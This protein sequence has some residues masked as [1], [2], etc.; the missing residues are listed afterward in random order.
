[1]DEQS[2][3]KSYS[4]RMQSFVSDPELE[5]LDLK[6]DPYLEIHQIDD[7]LFG[8]DIIQNPPDQLITGKLIWKEGYDVPLDLKKDILNLYNKHFVD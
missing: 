1:M 4:D 3:G 5:L 2:S 8:C 7:V 6:Y